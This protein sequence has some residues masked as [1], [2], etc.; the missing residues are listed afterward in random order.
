[1]V[2]VKNSDG[3]M[4]IVNVREAILLHLLT[5]IWILIE[6]HMFFTY[7]PNMRHKAFLNGSTGELVVFVVKFMSFISKSLFVDKKC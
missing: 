2:D 7:Y 6:S 3:G 4:L 1:M 5:V